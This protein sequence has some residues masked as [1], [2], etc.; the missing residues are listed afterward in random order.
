VKAIVEHTK[1]KIKS[2]LEFLLSQ[3]DI[4]PL[5]KKLNK[6]KTRF[7]SKFSLDRASKNVRVFPFKA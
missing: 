5:L 1:D 3:N 7:D 6:D 4:L 2:N